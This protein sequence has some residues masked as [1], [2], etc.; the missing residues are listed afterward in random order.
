[1]Q[2]KWR[3]LAPN[4]SRTGRTLPCW[5]KGELARRAQVAQTTVCATEN[6]ERGPHRGMGELTVIA[7]IAA[8]SILVADPEAG[9]GVFCQFSDNDTIL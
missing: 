3:L 9:F 8:G 1:M 2:M 6:S 5:S 4:Q 7:L